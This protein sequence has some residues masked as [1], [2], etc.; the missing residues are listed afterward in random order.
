MKLGVFDSGIGGE[1]VAAQL[2]TAFSDAE[3]ITVNDRAHL[4]YGL[5]P[6]AE[7]RHLTDRALQPLL[8]AGCDVIVIACNTATAAAID[9]LRAR[10]PQ[11]GFV[12]LE[13][14]L[15][16]AAGLTDSGVVA[17]CATPGTLASRRYQA[18]KQ[19]WAAGLQVLEPDCADW[20]SLIE[21]NR[22]QEL[23]LQAMVDELCAA[24]A[25]VIVLACTHYHW[26][27]A[28]IKTA[29]AGRARILQPTAAIVR[30]VAQ[31]LAKLEQQPKTDRR[32][33]RNF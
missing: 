10:Y 27:E 23:R 12:G 33:Q 26:I 8:V 24:G 11:T 25:D 5:R 19:R 16:T 32:D 15:K 30:R 6:A 21:A 9:W 29:A 7:V 17:I 4:P 2:R 18:S 13:P 20:A 3:I 31:L 22:Q 1:A 14:M 28:E